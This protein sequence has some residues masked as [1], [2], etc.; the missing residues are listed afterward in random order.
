MFSS[1]AVASRTITCIS[2]VDHA[3]MLMVS[4]RKDISL[5]HVGPWRSTQSPTHL[6]GFESLML[7][8]IFKSFGRPH[9]DKS[10]FRFKH[11]ATMLY[12]GSLCKFVAA[13]ITFLRCLFASVDCLHIFRTRK[14]HVLMICGWPIGFHVK[15]LCTLWRS[16][17][18]FYMLLYR[19]SQ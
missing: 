1:W 18:G 16:I 3:K 4:F 17:C 10:L 15:M 7:T 13:H 11:W 2:F 8:Y 5:L 14:L 6:F 9:T 12:G 19:R